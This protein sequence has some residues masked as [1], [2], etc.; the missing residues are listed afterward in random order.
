[1]PRLLNRKIHPNRVRLAKAEEHTTALA[2]SGPSL[3]I[4]SAIVKDDTAKSWVLARRS[5]LTNVKTVAELG[6]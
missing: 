2:A 1:M 4:C 3:S 6:E 5:D